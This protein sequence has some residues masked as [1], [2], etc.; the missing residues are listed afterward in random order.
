M[1]IRQIKQRNQ[2]S[3]RQKSLDAAGYDP[4]IDGTYESAIAIEYL[5][6]KLP[7]QSSL[8]RPGRLPEKHKP[9]A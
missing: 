5:P 9:G 7:Q 8:R 3:I 4:V 1:P 6:A 2:T